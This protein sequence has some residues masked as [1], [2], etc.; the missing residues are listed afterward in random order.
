LV[1]WHRETSFAGFSW[2]PA[3]TLHTQHLYWATDAAERDGS[4]YWYVS[5]GGGSIA[6][7]KGATPTGPWEDP[8]G[9]RLFNETDGH[10]L[11]PK[12]GIRDPGVLADDDG[13]YY[14]VFGSC[15]GSV[16]PD[17][18]CYYA[19]E[20]RED[21]VSYHPPRHLSVQGAMG[22]YG[23]GKA[24]DK[25]FLHKRGDTYY[26][27]WGA[28]YAT[29]SSPYGPYRY[30]G[31]FLDTGRIAPAFLMNKTADI[32]YHEEDYHDRHG[33]FLH[34]H[35]QW[36]FFCNDRSHS[37]ALRYNL[38]GFVFRDT[39]A[40]YVHYFR[41]GSIAPLVIDAQGVGSHDFSQDPLLPA[42]HFFSVEG[43][44]KAEGPHGGLEPELSAP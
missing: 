34:L 1:H 23:P 27:S 21:M 25:P 18:S 10:S 12:T 26:L 19:A 39:V 38:S 22:P 40:A 6:V 5:V 37:D 13:R 31:T 35:G 20:L 36:Y 7:L 42:E 9:H 8:L 14:I 2:E 29:A 24:D 44:E 16:Q 30:R 33:S 11:R 32:W 15:S 3:E 4:F 43:G 17:D 41:N 28:F